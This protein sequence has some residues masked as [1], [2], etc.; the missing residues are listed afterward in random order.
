MSGWL[1][2]GCCRK[3]QPKGI[4]DDGHHVH[5]DGDDAV[6]TSPGQIGNAMRMTVMQD[7]APE[8]TL[9]PALPTFNKGK[10][11][12]EPTAAA[13]LEIRELAVRTA[14]VAAASAPA[15]DSFLINAGVGSSSS[16]WSINNTTGS[17]WSAILAASKL[18][19]GTGGTPSVSSSNFWGLT[20]SS[21]A[22]AAMFVDTTP[23]VSLPE[24]STV[25]GAVLGLTSPVVSAMSNAVNFASVRDTFGITDGNSTAL[26]STLM[27]A[28]D[29]S[30]SLKVKLN[31]ASSRTSRNALWAV[32]GYDAYRVVISLVFDFTTSGPVAQIQSLVAKYFGLNLSLV[33][34]MPQVIMT[35]IN[36]YTTPSQGSTTPLTVVPSY[37]MELCV[38]TATLRV[39]LV[40][41]PEGM[42]VAVSDLGSTTP[43]NKPIFQRLSDEV[44]PSTGAAGGAKVPGADVIPD[45][46]KPNPSPFD[47]LLSEA[48]LWYAEIDLEGQTTAAAGAPAPTPVLSN[49]FWQ[50]GLLA[51]I[52]PTSSSVS[53]ETALTLDTRVSSYEGLLIFKKSQPTLNA[54]R[55]YDLETWIMPPTWL[56]YDDLPESFDLGDVFGNT[57]PPP[58]VP[59]KITQGVI[60]VSKPSSGGAYSFYVACSVTGASSGGTGSS[61][62]N[63]APAS[64]D[65]SFVDLSLMVSSDG[66]MDIQ[67]LSRF[68]LD[69]SAS[70]AT[71]PPLLFIN[72]QYST[73][74]FWKLEAEA[75]NIPLAS[76]SNHFDPDPKVHSHV[77]GAVG[78]LMLKDVHMLYVFKK[79]DASS[80]LITAV[81][82]L[83]DL[84]LDLYY[85][86]DTPLLDATDKS[87]GQLA[88]GDTPP[89]NITYPARGTKPIWKFEAFLGATTPDSNLKSIITS[90]LGESKSSSLPDFLTGIKV[91]AASGGNSAVKL[92]MSKDDS[93]NIV[94][95]FQI[96]LSDLDFTYASVWPAPSSAGSSV[97]KIVIR[98]G[99]DKI[100]LID[101]IPLI[102]ELPQPFD[103]IEYLYVDDG[104]TGLGLSTNEIDNMINKLLPDGAPKFDY[105][106]TNQ[107]GSNIPALQGGHHFMVVNKGAVILDHVFHDVSTPD[108]TS[109]AEPAQPVTRALTVPQEDAPPSKGKVDVQLPFLSISAV[110]LKFKG[111][112]LYLDIDATMVLGPIQGTVIGFEVALD[113]SKKVQLNHLENM[114]TDGNITFGIHGLS[115][116]V[117]E[118][119]LVIAGVFIHDQQTL[120]SSGGVPSVQVERYAGGVSVG[121]EAWQFTAVGAYEIILQV[122]GD[123][124][125][126]YKSVF[127]YAKLNGPLFTLAFAS[128]SGVRAGFGYNSIVRSPSMTELPHFPFLDDQSA[129]DSSNGDV[130]ALLKSFME[131]DK[132]WVSPK[133]DSYWV[134]VVCIPFFASLIPPFPPCL[135]PIFMIWSCGCH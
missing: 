52:N 72:L 61:N 118:D 121:F 94:L 14:H 12:L 11:L 29:G 23:V 63:A 41:T 81:L 53:V 71:N 134:A 116:A 132:P 119:P 35:S 54:L 120:P 19:P 32:P 125:N 103:K 122:Q 75:E 48:K 33:N 55:Q 126:G 124:G 113:L 97:G 129:E 15:P 86:Y 65:F 84:E 4:V 82:L 16:S 13:G 46:S 74:K 36:T 42:K 28:I 70:A 128:V 50:L 38:R 17:A 27:G 3:R 98:V 22:N 1:V 127:V 130:M 47:K 135:D 6:T 115:I 83:G 105:V 68:L 21:S 51:R 62:T 123:T 64:F 89:D 30:K 58:Q 87:A 20:F 131:G 24:D 7:S 25:L 88:W 99:V 90:I 49:V 80:F 95:A 9:T 78:G 79:G 85:Q 117:D 57:K 44:G 8:A 112:K 77:V 104:G 31:P 106:K 107:D 73:G 111:M 37:K 76:L 100:P 5:N 92:I 67:M 18:T 91:G 40:F 2:C 114:L 101:Q 109:S 43:S 108:Q 59:T 26:L 34:E 10:N 133:E 45:S 93:D 56:T 110:T 60:R 39:V 69:S 96:V 66:T 102:K